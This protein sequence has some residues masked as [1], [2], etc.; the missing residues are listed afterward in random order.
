MMWSL[1]QESSLQRR[2]L[3]I[4]MAGQ[5]LQGGI[6]QVFR[7]RSFK[8]SLSCQLRLPCEPYGFSSFSFWI[9]SYLV[10]L[11]FGALLNLRQVL[12]VRLVHCH[13]A[14]LESSVSLLVQT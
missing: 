13:F 6:V 10:H 7:S 9:S 3:S 14:L 1:R 5:S 8:S 2:Q 12:K 4:Q 11:V